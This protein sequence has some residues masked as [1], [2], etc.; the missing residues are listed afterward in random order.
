MKT[1][2]RLLEKYIYI[3]ICINIY[4]YIYIYSNQHTYIYIYYIYIFLYIYIHIYIY[5]YI[6]MYANIHIMYI[7][8]I[9]NW[10]FYDPCVHI[11]VKIMFWI[12]R[13]INLTLR[14]TWRKLQKSSVMKTY[15]VGFNCDDELPYKKWIQKRK[16]F[17]RSFV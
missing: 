13:K 9:N 1:V 17:C 6:Y 14:D 5:I 2:R 4:I 16:P 11:D 3:Y 8:Q 7:C 12:L 15:S 10:H